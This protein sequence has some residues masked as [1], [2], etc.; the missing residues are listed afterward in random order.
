MHHFS[1]TPLFERGFVVSGCSNQLH[2]VAHRR[3][4]DKALDQ[5]GRRPEFLSPTTLTSFFPYADHACTT[6]QKP[7]SLSGVSSVKAI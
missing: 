3:G 4:A 7:R 2:V 1:E 5:W 6:S